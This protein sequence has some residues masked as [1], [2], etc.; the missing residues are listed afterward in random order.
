M[1]KAKK[2]AEYQY[3]KI[4]LAYE[5]PK[6]PSRS[7]AKKISTN[8][9]GDKITDENVPNDKDNSTDEKKFIPTATKQEFVSLLIILVL[10]S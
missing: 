7:K 2:A 3:R 6:W 10:S 5:G 8:E 1:L 4:R 9:A